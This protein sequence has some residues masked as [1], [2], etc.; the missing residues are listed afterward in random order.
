MRTS[1][2]SP[3]DNSHRQT[4][5]PF[6]KQSTQCQATNWISGW[7]TSHYWV[8]ICVFTE[9]VAAGC[10]LRRIYKKKFQRG[11]LTLWQKLA[12]FAPAFPPFLTTI[13]M[14]EIYF[15]P[16]LIQPVFNVWYQSRGR[17]LVGGYFVINYLG[18]MINYM[19]MM[20]NYMDMMINYMA[21]MIN[22][23][24][25]MINYLGGLGS[26]CCAT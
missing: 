20:I 14:M 18:M 10:R 22:S 15:P 16:G 19:V 7:K 9:L 4:R 3:P 24:G 1:R 23:L 17:M 25:M 13:Q 5:S 12:H 8:W 11:F 6:R 2:E 21:M 26:W